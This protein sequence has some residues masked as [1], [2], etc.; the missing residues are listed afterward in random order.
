MKKGFVVLE[1]ERRLFRQYSCLDEDRMQNYPYPN[2][3]NT[4]RR[5]GGYSVS[6]LALMKIVCKITLTL[7][8]GILL[9]M[10]V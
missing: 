5:K 6:I 4:W 7:I 10:C 9:R 8:S 2:F 3:R 1:E